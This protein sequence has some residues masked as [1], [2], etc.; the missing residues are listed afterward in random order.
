[1]RKNDLFELIQSLNPQE[2]KYFKQFSAR[3]KTEDNRYILLFDLIYA[4]PGLPESEIRHRFTQ[5]AGDTYYPKR[6]SYLYHALIKFLVWENLE[7]TDSNKQLFHLLGF[8][9]LIERKLYRQAQDVME[10]NLAFHNRNFL[11]MISIRNIAEVA[12]ITKN[13]ALRKKYLDDADLNVFTLLDQEYKAEKL[14]RIN[15]NMRILYDRLGDP[16]T[17]EEKKRYLRILQEVTPDL[18][19]SYV[20]AHN[21]YRNLKYYSCKLN[22]DIE[23]CLHILEKMYAEYIQESDLRNSNILISFLQLNDTLIKMCF[24]LKDIQKMNTYISALSILPAYSGITLFMRDLLV[25]EHA[26]RSC[27][28]SG[29]WEEGIARMR[30]FAVWERENALSDDVL[31]IKYDVYFACVLFYF[32][33]KDFNQAMHY[34]HKILNEGPARQKN[35]AVYVNALILQL[36]AL[37]SLENPVSLGSS[38]RSA[39]YALKS[40]GRY[41]A[42]EKL[43]IAYVKRMHRA[44]GRKEKYALLTELQSAIERL[45]AIDTEVFGLTGILESGWLEHALAD[46]G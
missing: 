4:H 41:N 36:L 7:K 19:D 15:F 20:I 40:L 45:K 29:Q 30:Q 32:R 35:T 6:K 44:T 42:T 3:H 46:H 39:V 26:L 13:T 24:D 5:M 17:Q 21:I 1:M 27:I 25:F 33:F 22:G 18:D 43:F 14:L 28:L 2:V 38:L 31:H 34:I 37:F 8:N 9:M 16:R 10:E 23:G 12:L 11:R